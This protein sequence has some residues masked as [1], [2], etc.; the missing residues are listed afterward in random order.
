MSKKKQESVYELR[1][2]N[3]Q[4]KEARVVFLEAGKLDS[5]M[6]HSHDFAEVVYVAEGFG[7]STVNGKSVKIKS[8]DLFLL[9]EKGC[10]HCIKPSEKAENF[11][12]YNL[13]V[14]YDL[15]EIDLKKI[16]PTFIFTENRISGLYGLMAAIKREEDEKEEG[17][18]GMINALA[19]VLLRQIVRKYPRTVRGAQPGEK[20]DYVRLAK[21]YISVNYAYPITVGDVATACGITTDYLQELFKKKSSLS[22]KQWLMCERMRNSCYRLI[23]TDESVEAVAHNC[24]FCDFK[25]FYRKFKITFGMTP[26]EYRH[27]MGKPSKG[28]E[29]KSDAP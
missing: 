25:Y 14:P 28:T 6:P 29:S 4:D 19:E 13:I 8:G 7:V 15:F 21:K 2:E 3:Y 9:A 27:A 10:V 16:S 17:F 24:G 18:V 1:A 11:R 20:C 12:I 23:N 5:V 22:V 26:T